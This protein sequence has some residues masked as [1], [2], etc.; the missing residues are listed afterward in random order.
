MLMAGSKSLK[1][2]DVKKGNSYCS[3]LISLI[4]V[5][6]TCKKLMVPADRAQ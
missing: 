3:G 6:N 4:C 5:A 2:S 1:F